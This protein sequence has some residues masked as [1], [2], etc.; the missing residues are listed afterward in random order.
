M[1]QRFGGCKRRERGKAR[2]EPGVACLDGAAWKQP[3][4]LEA[5]RKEGGKTMRNLT[6]QKKTRRSN[7]KM[8][9]EKEETRQPEKGSRDR[10]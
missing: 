5:A 9:E 3:R 6:G 4:R 1:R 7:K 8:Q 10:A 2:S